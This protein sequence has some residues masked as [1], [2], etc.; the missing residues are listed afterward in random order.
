VTPERIEMDELEQQLAMATELGGGL[1]EP[2]GLHLALVI[3]CRGEIAAEVY[4]PTAGPDTALISWSMAKSFTHAMVG[5]LVAEGLLDPSAP[6]PVP[7]WAGDHRSAITLQQLLE[8]SSGLAFVEDYVDGDVSNV[9]E[10]LFGDGKDDVARYAASFPLIHEP[11]AVFN[12]SSGTTNIISAIC[13]R[14]IRN[15]GVAAG[16]EAFLAERLFEPLG[17]TSATIRCDP[18]GTFIGSSFVYATARDFATFGRLYLDDGLIRGS[19][20]ATRRLLP[21]GWVDHARTPVRAH[22]PEAHWYGAHWWLWDENCDPGP[23]GAGFDCSDINGFGAHG[24]QGQY[25][26]VV[27]DRDLVIVRLGKTPTDQ[28]AQVRAWI[29]DIV[30]C[31]PAT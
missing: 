10:M 25:T 23:T 7:E 5:L 14:A 9:I 13:D 12:Y 19:D 2:F 22:V 18:T 3:V 29:A 1:E 17:M 31:F 28:Q 15:S 11:G 24:Y 16:T 8:M 30:R 6:A 21:E 26:L 20:G 4:G 27:P